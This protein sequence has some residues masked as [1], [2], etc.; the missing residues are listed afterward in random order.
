MAAAKVDNNPASVS[1]LFEG[2]WAARILSAGP[3]HLSRLANLYIIDTIIP[4]S[5]NF[6]V[7][8]ERTLV[9]FRLES[10]PFHR[11]DIRAVITSFSMTK[12]VGEVMAADINFEADGVPESTF[13]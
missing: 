13:Y 11:I 9:R 12:S 2:K 8:R 5:G 6:G 10:D 3:C 1:G 4:R 7:S